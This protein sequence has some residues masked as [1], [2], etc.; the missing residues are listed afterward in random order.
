ML[1]A[2][3]DVA[4]AYCFG[5][6]Q[7]EVM[8]ASLYGKDGA[9]I[10]EAFHFPSA[11]GPTRPE[12]AVLTAQVRREHDDGY[13]VALTS[14]RFIYGARIEAKGFLADD[15]YLHLVPGRT[16]HIRLRNITGGPAKLRG[17]VE[18]LALAEPLR[19]ASEE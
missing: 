12:G 11:T 14:D 7:H 9:L 6:P 17:F 19:L 2:F 3:H 8:V 1:G 4:Y 16:K 10:A 13:T 5:P 15:N 18:A